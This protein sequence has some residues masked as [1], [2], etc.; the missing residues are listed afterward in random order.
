[1]E[2]EKATKWRDYNS[3]CE[4]SYHLNGESS[5]KLLKGLV[6]PY[7]HSFRHPDRV[8]EQLI[9]G[10]P[11]DLQAMNYLAHSIWAYALFDGLAEVLDF[12]CLQ[13]KLRERVFLVTQ[14][15]HNQVRGVH[16]FKPTYHYGQSSRLP[17]VSRKSVLE[18]R[19]SGPLVTELVRRQA[20]WIPPWM[21]SIGVVEPEIFVSTKKVSEFSRFYGYHSHHLIWGCTK[22]D[23]RCAFGSFKRNARRG[24][25][26]LPPLQIKEIKTGDLARPISYLTKVPCKQRQIYRD[27]E[28]NLKTI[29]GPVQP[30]NQ[31]RCARELIGVTLP[32]LTIATGQGKAVLDHALDPD[33]QFDALMAIVGSRH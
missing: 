18:A 22:S 19:A 24:P 7:Q 20:L 32:E 30:I 4:T 27:K 25:S 15:D 21:N 29:P 28:K 23:I 5:D 33:L 1:M 2:N 3:W 10:N 6:Q 11:L 16:A 31:V 8:I 12:D 9:Y 14:V 13:M 17:R 26:D